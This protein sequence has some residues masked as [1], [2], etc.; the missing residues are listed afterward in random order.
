MK[1]LGPDRAYAAP[2]SRPGERVLRSPEGV[3][4]RLSLRRDVA[5]F[6]DGRATIAPESARAGIAEFRNNLTVLLGGTAPEDVFSGL[7]TQFDLFVGAP[8]KQDP[9]PRHPFPTLALVA[10][11]KDAALRAEWLLG[12]QTTIGVVNAQAAQE[13]APR[14]L[15]ETV[16]GSGVPVASARYLAELLPE[17]DDDRLQ[18]RPSLAF[19]EGRMILGTHPDIV[20]ALAAGAVAGRFEPRPRGDALLLDGEAAA[21]AL[22]AAIPFLAPREALKSGDSEA[23]VARRLRFAERLL[24]RAGHVRAAFCV[25]GA[26]AT[27]SL[28]LGA[29]GRDA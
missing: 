14:F 28:G 4:A 21:A 15:L 29:K 25:D 8:P 18:L 9:A 17:G 5:A 16:E 13:R 26:E 19:A 2:E 27:F 22:S 3:V 6:W 23:E 7:G 11:V 12:F 10:E 1:P 24:R 20:G